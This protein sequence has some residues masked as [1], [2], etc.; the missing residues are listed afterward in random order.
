V[1]VVL[2][3][4]GA[5]L[6]AGTDKALSLELYGYAI[7]EAGG[8]RDFIAVASNL[9]LAKVGERLRASGLQAHATFTLPPGRYSLRFLLRDGATGRSGTHWM[10]VSVP[11]AAPGEVVLLPPLFMDDPQRFLVVQAPSS[12]SL[13]TGSPF[14]VG[15]AAFTPRPRPVAANGREQRVCVLAQ[16]VGRAYDAGT[17]FEIVPSLVDAAGAPVAI[18]DLRLSQAVADD[19]GYRRFVLSF[20][21]SGVPAGDYNLRVRVRDPQS[22]RVG[23]SFQSVRVE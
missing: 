21:P 14:R 9:D 5:D 1:P 10:E 12:A 13:S 11:E 17:S 2:E 6:L 23:E 22:G 7:D 16:D 3:A 15:A 20:T 8:V 4:L 19:D 18:A